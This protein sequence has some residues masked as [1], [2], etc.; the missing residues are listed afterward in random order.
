MNNKIFAQIPK[1][2]SELGAIGKER[3]NTHQNYSFRGIEDMYNAIN[4]LLVK[5]GVFCVPQ[6]VEYF[7]E[8]FPS[9]TGATSFRVLLKMNHRFYADDG[10]YIE[11]MTMGEGI[12]TSDKAS[13]KA[14]SAA[15]KYA[16][17]ELFSIP[18][19]DV[20][21][22]DED[23]PEVDGGSKPA[24]NTSFGPSGRSPSFGPRNV[25]NQKF[26]G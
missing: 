4:P 23:H 20:V 10:S 2:M 6:V 18:T 5:N 22:G 14:T 25:N 24:Q 17:I 16:F 19:E 3:K 15:M 9:K 7:T 21:D 8:T 12:D 13:N 11:V 1:I 26:G